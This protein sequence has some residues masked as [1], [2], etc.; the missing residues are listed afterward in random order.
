MTSRL[1][2]LLIVPP[3]IFVGIFFFYPLFNIFCISFSDPASRIVE[4][5]LKLLETP[6]FRQVLWFTTWQAGLSTLITLIIAFPGA[7]VFSQYQFRGKSLIRALMLIPFVLPTM[8]TAAAFKALLGSRGVINTGLMFFLNLDQPPIHLDQTVYCVLMAH[9]FY[10]YAIVFRLVS[11]FWERCPKDLPEASQML[12]AS[13]LKTFFKVTLPILTPVILA[14]SLLVFVFCF[15][16]FGVILILGGPRLATIEVEIYRQAVHLFNLPRAAVVSLIQIVFTFICMR[17]YTEIESRS[18]VSL[19]PEMTVTRTSF[20]GRPL[21]SNFFVWITVGL[22]FFLLGSPL[23]ALFI[24]SILTENGFSLKYYI[25]LFN[26][27]SRSIMFVPPLTAMINSIF[28]ALSTTVMAVIM[29]WFTAA[30][31]YRDT[32]GKAS[33]IDSMFMLPLSTSAVTLGFGFIVAFDSPPLNIRTSIALPVFA[34]TLIAYPFVIRSLLPAWRSIPKC[35]REAAAISGASPWEVW[36]HVD[37]PILKRA[38]LVGAVFS[39]AVSMGEFGATVFIARPQTPTMPL[40]IYR[41]F[42]LPGAMNYGQAMAM[43]C[44]LMVITALGGV[45]IERMAH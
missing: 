25:A 36:C 12:G 5:L 21:K 30:F 10:N 29:G 35:L 17:A 3:F 18:G 42:S 13:G 39:F 41:F 44:I 32:Q 26:N 16:S 45:V 19:M 22:L 43:A 34:H 2:Y 24:E 37:W 7:Y 8:V 23:I 1:R 6:Y 27:D 28:F 20:S 9:V 31:L 40:A 38:L 14:A 11:G 4:T 33:V 15:T